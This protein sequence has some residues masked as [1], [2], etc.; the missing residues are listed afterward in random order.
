[1]TKSTELAEWLARHG[2]GQYADRFEENNIEYSFLPE[3][4][5]D[6]LKKL[7]VSSLGHR[8]KLL[9]AIEALRAARQPAGAATGR[10]SLVQ[11]R[12]A[13]FRQ[14]TVLF[15]DLVG[16]TQLSEKLDPE[17]LQKLI[18][19]YRGA[20]STAIRRYGGEV[21]RY[22]GDGAMAFFGW[23]YAHEDDAARAIHAALEIV[24]GVPKISGPATLTCRVGVSSGP[25]VV[26]EIG[27]SGTWSMDAVGE[28]PNIAAR[29]QT[30]AAGN[31]VI[32]SESTRRLVSSAF[33]FQDLGLQE[34]KGVTEP[35]H[36]YRVISAKSTASRFEAAH[37]GS[38]TPLIGRSSELSLLLD[39][40]QKAK[41]GD[42]QVVFL[43]GI[44]G[45]GKSR[46]LHELKLHIQQE[47]RVWV[48]HQ[49]S[50]YHSQSA[51]V[52]VIEQIEQA[53]QITAREADADKLAKLK[54]YLPRST[55]S[56]KEAVLLIAKL[57]SIPLENHLEFADLT[58]QQI[59]NRTIS[60]LVDMLLA[61]SV[62]RPTVCIFEDAHWLDPST[63]ELL[64][65][66]ISRIHH[67]RV[68]LIVSCRPEFRPT[69]ITHAN[70]TVHSLTRLSHAEVKAMIRDLLRGE[71]MPQPLLDQIIEKADG[72]PLFIEE[73]TNSMLGA[74]LRTRGTFERAARPE[75]LRVPDTLSDA[76]ME[77]L[78][79]VAPS[80][81]L[82]Q[83]AAVIGREFSYD[84]LSAAS[85]VDEDDMLSALSLLEQADIIHRVDI[86]PFVRFAFKH[87]LLRDAIYDSLL[88]GKR[89][90]IHADIAAI[91]K[92]DFPELAESQ[93]EVLAYHYQ[94]AGN[95]QLAIR[96]WFESGQR[97]LAHSANVEAIASFRKALQLLSALPETPERTKHE[98]DIQLALGIPLIAVHGYA[99]A[100]T[101][102]AF[103]R[104][105]ALC[106]QLGDI[107]EY[108]QALY[109]LCMHSW[110]CARHDEALPMA[111][112]FLSRSQALSD[113]VLLMVAHRVMGST[114]LTIGDFQLSANH[115]EETI[116]LSSGKEKQ[117]LSGLYMVE[118]QV[119]S[120]LL[121][122]WDLWF[123]GHPDQALLRVS[124]AL[125]LAQDLG[126][127]YT[128]AF[129]HYMTSVVHLLRGD[130]ARA[131]ESAEKSFEMSQEQRFSLYVIL[132]RISRG[133]ALG[134]LGRLTEARAEIAMGIDEAR[135]NGLG[136]ML[137]MMDSWLADMHARAGEN[138]RALSI[139][140]GVL[141][142]VGD[143]TGRS[144]EAELHRQRAQILLA[145]NPSK[146]SEAESHLKK[147][148][149]VARGQSA[150]SLE[151]RAAIS[152]AELWRTQ[153]RSDEARALLEPICRSFD[154]GAETADLKRARAAILHG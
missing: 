57:L 123:L 153:G 58:P 122:S 88:R 148:I 8:K 35:L 78:D 43:S 47:P 3:L 13:E 56:S 80:R 75:T 142:S 54:A 61:F 55:Y 103:S 147:S 104:A 37:A 132:S 136:F 48:H 34:L 12:E 85:Q 96:S 150:R 86:S 139:V 134:E 44:P 119:A 1:M 89:Q 39:R 128:Q 23:P 65:L 137:Q 146:V 79:R 18:D 31:T 71:S 28:T 140:D 24:T 133:R 72:V 135:R 66:I 102:E 20:C 87:V 32:I 114:L 109:G 105:R 115:F 81:R 100:E 111:E 93:P 116:K 151:L 77:R 62:Q 38:L 107:P 14:I 45:V 41:E 73:L 64:E 83:I 49:G 98:I 52:P 124:E 6:D 59:K 154:E 51:F 95:H 112:E 60:T 7:G 22:F 101:C 141:A 67:A 16:S 125:A 40:W 99:S 17:D 19:A 108:F 143:V 106:L 46:L 129:A 126:H 2:L 33:D 82:A 117:P 118:P 110:M 27:D 113:P 90:Q 145:L 91:L 92:H 84:L 94:E 63:L 9:R 127:P 97:A 152:L 36:V 68:L 15:S 131:F 21:A 4:T 121:L 120:L 130:S 29:L 138:E 70:A 5:D 144:W 149:E 30:L 10:P 53:A 50:P 74:P 26:G 42:G 69:W 25:V 11:H 76:F